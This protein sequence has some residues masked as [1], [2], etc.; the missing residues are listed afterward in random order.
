MKTHTE[1]IETSIRGAKL[2]GHPLSNEE[3]EALDKACKAKGV[4][5][6]AFISLHRTVEEVQ[7]A[8]QPF[9]PK[10]GE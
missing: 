5:I 1:A 9:M 10:A 3:V 4:T 7:R 6:E 2:L 8:I